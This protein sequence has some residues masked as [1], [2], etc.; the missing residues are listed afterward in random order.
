MTD[1]LLPG[2]DAMIGTCLDAA[3]GAGWSSDTA[4]NDCAIAY[5]QQQKH[6]K[7]TCR[8]AAL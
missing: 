2:T 7:P 4:P 6:T 5:W 3:N 1:R 8:L